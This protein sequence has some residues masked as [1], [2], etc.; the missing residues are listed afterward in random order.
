MKMNF[1]SHN[2]YISKISSKCRIKIIQT[3]S[4]HPHKISTII[5]STSNHPKNS[6][7][8]NLPSPFQQTFSLSPPT[9]PHKTHTYEANIHSSQ[10]RRSVSLGSSRDTQH[11]WLV[12][13]LQHPRALPPTW[14]ARAHGS[15]LRRYCHHHRGPPPPPPPPQSTAS[16]PPLWASSGGAQE[17]KGPEVS[18]LGV[19]WPKWAARVGAL[20]VR[21]LVK[22]GNASGGVHRFTREMCGDRM[23]YAN[24]A[25]S[26]RINCISYE[27]DGGR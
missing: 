21:S 26:R 3:K 24:R 7:S 23:E 22:G 25:P 12:E 18:A 10:K 4:T 6:E 17:A 1:N 11:G 13:P 14:P 27:S 5:S 20:G 15:S 8:R 2:Y 16:P 19:S 9:N